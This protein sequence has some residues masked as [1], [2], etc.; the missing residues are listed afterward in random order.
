VIYRFLANV[1]VGLHL[2][3]IIFAV[4]GGLLVGKWKRCAWLHI[5]AF[6]WAVFIELNGWICPL[7]PLENWLRA[8]GGEVGYEVG[9]IE[10][11]LLP[12]IYPS[13]LT[14]EVQIALGLLVL[15][16]NLAVY[17]WLLKRSFKQ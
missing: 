17:G 8:R 15:I 11:Y 13:A 12:I 7:T 2:A 5:P 3:F 9:F 10:H 6:L 16:L 14:R 4:V 1:V